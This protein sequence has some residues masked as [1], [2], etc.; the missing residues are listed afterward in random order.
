MSWPYIVT[1]WVPGVGQ[2]WV[3]VVGEDEPTA[4]A[5]A[6]TASANLRNC[7]VQIRG[8]SMKT[9]DLLNGSSITFTD[10]AGLPLFLDD[11]DYEDREPEVFDLTATGKDG[12]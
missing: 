7:S 1:A 10:P 2:R 3:V 5:V 6:E 9:L 11:A 12:A 8:R 4:W